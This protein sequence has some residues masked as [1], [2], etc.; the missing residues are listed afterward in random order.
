MIII[1]DTKCLIIITEDYKYCLST[2]NILNFSRK[3][4][5]FYE[6]ISRNKLDILH[7]R[8]L[9]EHYESFL[10]LEEFA[11]GFLKTFN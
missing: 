8:L 10:G 3:I 5:D 7:V 6:L 4:I 11:I 1:T 9:N 2:K